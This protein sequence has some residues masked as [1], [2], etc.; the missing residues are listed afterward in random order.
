MKKS[1]QCGLMVSSTVEPR[2]NC[3][4]SSVTW[5]QSLG[6]CVT[7]LP[8]CEMS[9]C[10]QLDTHSVLRETLTLAPHICPQTHLHITKNKSLKGA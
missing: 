2:A 5:S 1:K 3:P 10:T 4:V 9:I 6:L 7:P 8:L